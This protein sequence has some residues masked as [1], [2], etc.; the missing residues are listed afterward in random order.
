MSILISDKVAIIAKNSKKQIQMLYKDKSVYQTRIHSN[1][2]HIS[3]KQYSCKIY[4]VKLDRN[5]KKQT[6]P[7]L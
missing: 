2:K 5:E 1:A 7:Q 4:K 3:T 6:D